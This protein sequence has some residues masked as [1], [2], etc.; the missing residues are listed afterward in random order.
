MSSGGTQLPHLNNSAFLPITSVN[1]PLFLDKQIQG[2]A[3]KL[4]TSCELL[5][6]KAT[7]KSFEC[8]YFQ[9]NCPY[10]LTGMSIQVCFPEILHCLNLI[11]AEFKI[12]EMPTA[13]FFNFQFFLF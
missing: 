13:F 9:K 2:C 7:D 6:M 5:T 8:D 10:S 3:E 11:Q 12:E 1:C 4:K